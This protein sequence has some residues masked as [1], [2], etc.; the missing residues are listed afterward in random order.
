MSDYKKILVEES[1]IPYSKARPG[2]RRTGFRGVTVHETANY[3]RNA[4]AR[5][6]AKYMQGTGHN[7][8]VSS[9]YYVDDE[10]AVRTIPE[11]EIAWHAGDGSKANGG[12]MN[13]VAIEIC[14]NW[15]YVPAE[16]TGYQSL[17]AEKDAT[18]EEKA[19]AMQRFAAAV[20]N[21]AQLA[22]EILHRNGKRSVDGFLWQHNNWSGKDCPHNIRKDIPVGWATF[23]Q[24]VQGRLDALWGAGTETPP[25]TEEP[26]APTDPPSEGGL[27]YVQ[28]GA[29]SKKANADALLA[30][31]KKAGFAKSFLKPIGKMYHVQVGAFGNESNAKAY[32]GQVIAKGFDAYIKQ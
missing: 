13:T 11:N 12:N 6:H 18:K 17:K 4:D 19:A 8:A 2:N 3:R 31:V 5:A 15:G 24:K 16:Y 7:I 25:E 20:D 22:A 10:R 32:A 28:V 1:I 21:A 27:Y 14:E 23:R 9:H 30:K 29:F 26:P